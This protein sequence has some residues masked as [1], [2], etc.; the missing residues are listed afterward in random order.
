M[1]ASEKLR[2]LDTEMT[3]GHDRTLAVH[4]QPG[5]LSGRQIHVLRDALPQIVTVT[6]WA[7]QTIKNFEEHG[8]VSFI[9]L[10]DSLEELDKALP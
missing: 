1:S 7:E 9:P 2:V 8:E 6:L 3:E 5:Y 4:E 10:I